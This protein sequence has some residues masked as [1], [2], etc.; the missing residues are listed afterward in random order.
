M[1]KMHGIKLERRRA[2]RP[3]GGISVSEIPAPLRDNPD[4]LEKDEE[5]WKALGFTFDPPECKEE[6]HEEYK[7]TAQQCKATRRRRK[8]YFPSFA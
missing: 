8:Y 2:G 7:L 6:N 5:Y 3:P 4:I 1:L